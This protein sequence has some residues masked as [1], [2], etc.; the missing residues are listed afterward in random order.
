M[1]CLCLPFAVRGALLLPSR[2]S[3]TLFPRLRTL[4]PLDRP[5]FQRTPSQAAYLFS[6]S[7][8]YRSTSTDGT[9][10]SPFKAKRQWPPDL[11]KLS[12]KHQFRL[13]RKYRRRAKLK[14]ARPTWSKWT[15]LVQ[16]SLI[17]FVL[18][19]AI[20]FM[21]IKDGGTNPFQSFR[22]SLWKILDDSGLAGRQP[23][24]M[25]ESTDLSERKTGV[26]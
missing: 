5:Q 22:E 26:S 2:A 14:Y 11:A 13:E 4:F 18:V 8:S 10:I 12:S 19:Y 7:S 24:R 1:N 15:K 16:W 6:S 17:L 23:R 3:P 25:A 9:Y 20:L 21:E